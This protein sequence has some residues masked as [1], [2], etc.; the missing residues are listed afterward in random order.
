M[1]HSNW[2]KGLTWYSE[3]FEKHLKPGITTWGEITPIYLFDD[4][5]PHLMNQC[6]PKAKLICC[7]R[8]QSDRA[9][10]WYR[11][12][13]RF[14]PDIFWTNYSFRQFMIY[15]TEV[16]GREGFY[17]DHL[18]KYFDMY[19]RESI[20]VLLYEDLEKDPTAYIQAVFRFL[21]VNPTF[22]PPSV[23][24][25]I[26]PMN[27]LLPRSKVLGGFLER[28]KNKL[29][30]S[31]IGKFLNQINTKEVVGA[32]FPSRHQLSSEIRERMFD[33]YYSHN[34]NLGEFLG[35]DL[36]HWNCP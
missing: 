20:L 16:Y 21:Q 1:V 36:N 7:L 24:K 11:L 9:F 17:L 12:F 15:H 3:Q 25:Q 8:D 2:S 30:G 18:Q 26:N 22:V 10:S 35:R 31:K 19:P 29:R 28:N 5:T 13:L 23:R 6:I 32:N 34:K 27:L 33:L 4:D 14:N